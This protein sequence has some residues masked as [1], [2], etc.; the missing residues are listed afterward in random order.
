[1][2]RVT[3]RVEFWMGDDWRSSEDGMTSENLDPRNGVARGRHPLGRFRIAT[4]T[5]APALSK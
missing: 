5:A 3:H 2:E 1:M 4:L